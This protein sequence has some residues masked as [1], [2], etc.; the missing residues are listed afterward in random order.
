MQ[1]VFCK[2]CGDLIYTRAEGDFRR[3][4]CGNVALD[5]SGDITRTIFKYASDFIAMEINEIKLL[6]HILFYD[7]KLGN[8]NVPDEFIGGWHGK[9]KIRVGSNIE[10]YRDLVGIESAKEIEKYME[11]L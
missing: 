3:C 11:E 4:S 9:F 5:R 2:A 6:H 10:F 8:I 1:A 7:Y